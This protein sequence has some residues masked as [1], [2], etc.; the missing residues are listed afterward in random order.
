MLIFYRVKV[1]ITQEGYKFITNEIWNQKK[2]YRGIT[3][4]GWVLKNKRKFLNITLWRVFSL[5]YDYMLKLY[6]QIVKYD[7]CL[8]Y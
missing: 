7:V 2:L 5:S 4:R 6:E 1:T 3:H 8:Y